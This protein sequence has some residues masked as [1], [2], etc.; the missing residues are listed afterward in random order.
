MTDKKKIVVSVMKGIIDSHPFLKAGALVMIKQ[1]FPADMLQTIL[2]ERDS[3]LFAIKVELT[4]R[5]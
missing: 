1:V 2:G 3:L 5:D 4:F